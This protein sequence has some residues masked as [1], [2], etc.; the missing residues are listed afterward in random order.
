MI[1]TEGI[2]YTGSKKTIIPKIIKMIEG[3]PIQKTLD[4]FAGTT[5]VGQAFKQL[6]FNVDSNDLA[7]YS[8]VFGTCYLR[9]NKTEECDAYNQKVFNELNNLPP[10]EGYFTEHYGGYDFDGS[11]VQVDGKKRIWQRKNT[12]KMDA[13][14]EFIDKWFPVSE[15]RMFAQPGDFF[16]IGRAITLTSLILALDRV[17][18]SL[19]HQVSYLKEW[20]KRSYGDLELKV[21]R[22]IPSDKL[23]NVLQ[24]DAKTIEKEYDLVYVDPPYGTNNKVTLTTRVRYASYYHIWT[25]ICKGDRPA[26]VGAANRRLDVSSD[27]LPGAISAYESTHYDVVRNEIAELIDRLNTKYI[28]FSYSSKSK[29][30]IEDLK[31]IF[32]KKLMMTAAFPYRENAMKNCTSNKKWLGDGSQNYEFLFL[33]SKC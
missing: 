1:E 29:V 32:G 22:L 13:I 16:D 15:K 31:D 4:A 17:D 5:R 6:G 8:K 24:Q 28:L 30:S 25:T 33:L 18:N 21:P 9:H 14:L 23:H 10:K 11:A 12:M 26:V 2:R 19:G 20:S 3:L 27:T 7:E